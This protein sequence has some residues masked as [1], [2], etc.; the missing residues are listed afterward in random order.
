M[1]TILYLVFFDEKS[2][3]KV[4]KCLHCHFFI[5]LMHHCLIKK[6]KKI[7]FNSECLKDVGKW[8]VKKFKGKIML[9][10]NFY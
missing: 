3:Q 5:D 10:V 8:S 9:F 1:E 2:V 7:L 6:K 4:Y